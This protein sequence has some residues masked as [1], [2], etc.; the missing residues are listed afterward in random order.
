MEWEAFNAD[1]QQRR[2]QGNRGTGCARR[3]AHL[4]SLPDHEVLALL[5]DHTLEKLPLPP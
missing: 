2:D 4:C 1:R 3:A 5:P